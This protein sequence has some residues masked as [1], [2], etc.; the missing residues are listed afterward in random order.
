MSLARITIRRS[1][2]FA[3][4][5]QS[6]LH[7]APHTSRAVVL[8]PISPF[9]QTHSYEPRHGRN[10]HRVRASS[11]AKIKTTNNILQTPSVAILD[12]HR[13]RDRL[14]MQC[15]HGH[16][17]LEHARSKRYLH[18]QC[19]HSC[20]S[21]MYSPVFHPPSKSSSSL[22]IPNSIESNS[23]TH[24]RQT[25]S[26]TPSCSSSGTAHEHAIAFLTYRAD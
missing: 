4:Y 8:C 11:R 6:Y 16:W 19:I 2:A 24:P 22:S 21:R 14:R 3:M 9:T 12:R 15:S 5:L 20:T 23:R 1:A 10:R 25:S 13:R 18:H 17:R 7:V 26:S